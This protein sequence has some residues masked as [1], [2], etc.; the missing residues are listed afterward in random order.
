MTGIEGAEE[1]KLAVVAGARLLTELPGFSAGGPQGALWAQL[2]EALVKKVTG[3]A[4][5]AG[6]AGGQEEEEPDFEEMQVGVA[7]GR[8]RR[9]WQWGVGAS[10]SNGPA[11]AGCAASAALPVHGC[12]AGKDQTAELPHV[13]V[14]KRKGARKGVSAP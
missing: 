9:E 8:C 12:Y 11:S 5:G 4:A 2:R 14:D 13:L 3:A 6:G 7:M 10:G 1:E